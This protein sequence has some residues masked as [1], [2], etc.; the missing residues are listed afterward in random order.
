MTAHR[1]FQRRLD[2]AEG[3]S[4]HVRIPHLPSQV[5]ACNGTFAGHGLEDE[6]VKR[7]VNAFAT[8]RLSV[9]H[10]ERAFV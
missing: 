10:E 2:G 7:T 5:L 9:Q 4:E 3:L 1:R 8:R 6:T